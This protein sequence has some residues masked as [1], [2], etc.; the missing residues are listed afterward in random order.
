MH[1]PWPHPSDQKV[2]A[3]SRGLSP[4]AQ[5][6]VRRLGS[7]VTHSPTDTIRIPA[8]V[9]EAKPM[10]ASGCLGSTLPNRIALDKVL[11]ES[12]LRN[13]KVSVFFVGLTDQ[14]KLQDPEV[15]LQS[16]P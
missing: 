9:A 15:C 5:P 1:I 2:G 14:I 10:P 12:I 7:H 16:R 4:W 3:V 11:T 13:S 8:A 6:F